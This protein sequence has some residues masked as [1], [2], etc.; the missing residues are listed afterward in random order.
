MEKIIEK[1]DSYNLF[2]NIIPGYLMLLFNIYYFKLNSLNI[3]EYII[4]AYFIGQ[5]LNRLGSILIGKVLLKFTKEEGLPYDRYISASNKD[6]KINLLLQERN[7][8]RTFCTLFIAC[9]IEMIFS[10]IYSIINISN[11][12]IIFILLFICLIIYSISYCKY[13]KYI[14]DRVRI[15]NKNEKG[16]YKK[17]NNKF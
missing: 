9:I 2:T 17:L 8:Y 1:L 14:A 5:T 15:S 7:T 12:V 10:K 11:D 13:N 3:A 6:K 4:I 16:S